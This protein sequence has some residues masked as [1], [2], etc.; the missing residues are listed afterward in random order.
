MPPLSPWEQA[1]ILARKQL[2]TNNAVDPRSNS[3][4][5]LLEG[6]EGSL[7]VRNY[8]DHA[9]RSYALTKW[10]AVNFDVLRKLTS[11]KEKIAHIVWIEYETNYHIPW[12]PL[13]DIAEVDNRINEII[14]EINDKLFANLDFS[15]SRILRHSAYNTFE[16]NYTPTER[17]NIE[18]LAQKLKKASKDAKATSLLEAMDFDQESD[19]QKIIKMEEVIMKL[20]KAWVSIDEETLTLL[21][22]LSEKLKPLKELDKAY[23]KLS[24]MQ[25]TVHTLGKSMA[26]S[27]ISE[28]KQKKL[29]AVLKEMWKSPQDYIVGDEDLVS[30]KNG[31]SDILHDKNRDSLHAAL[32]K[33]IVSKKEFQQWFLSYF[34]YAN[35]GTA[36]EELVTAK[37]K[38]FWH[39]VDRFEKGV[40]RWRWSARERVLDL[41]PHMV[42]W[43][44]GL[45]F[46]TDQNY[47]LANNYFTSFRSVFYADPEADRWT[48]DNMRAIVAAI[49]RR[50]VPA[51][52]GAQNL[53]SAWSK[54]LLR[55]S[56]G[57]FW[58]IY[59]DARDDAEI[60]ATIVMMQAQTSQELYYN[61][62]DKTTKPENFLQKVSKRIS[63]TEKWRQWVK[64]FVKPWLKW[65]LRIWENATRYAL[66]GVWSA[67]AWT[68]KMIAWTDKNAEG[69]ARGGLARMNRW[70]EKTF[71]WAK[72]PFYALWPAT[73]ALEKWFTLANQATLWLMVWWTRF[74]QNGI[75]ALKTGTHDEN[76]T[77]LVDG[78][79]KSLDAATSWVSKPISWI[80][81]KANEQS[82]K[83]EQKKF[84]AA[85]YEAAA[86]EDKLTHI[87]ETTDLANI[88][89][90][91]D[92]GPYLF[93]EDGR[94]APADIEEKTVESTPDKALAELNKTLDAQVKKILEGLAT[95]RS[96]MWEKVRT[97][98][99]L[100]DLQNTEAILWQQQ[101]LLDAQTHIRTLVSKM[102]TCVIATWVTFTP[103]SRAA[104]NALLVEIGA[105]QSLLSTDI[106]RK[107]S[108]M[109]IVD[110]R[111]NAADTSIGAQNWIIAAA[112]RVRANDPA[113]EAALNTAKNSKQKAEI[114]KRKIQS[115][116]Q[117]LTKTAAYL[118]FVRS[119]VDSIK[120][121]TDVIPIGLGW[122]VETNSKILIDLLKKLD[123]SLNP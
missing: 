76:V 60:F 123:L 66:T 65:L 49:I 9:L 22:S 67:T 81:Q 63:R 54:S 85:F 115:E 70:T 73:Y 57:R 21:D 118:M 62:K 116:L 77:H 114:E 3:I 34:A 68:T 30:L 10:I 19:P 41:H 108:R 100:N 79:G 23:K 12:Q 92:Y 46:G 32:D 58:S 29:F 72:L 42:A 51:V 107:N 1:R 52:A 99:A 26:N 82:T 40:D 90:L 89:N 36:K 97:I 106:I 56:G 17:Q 33:H 47:E 120:A 25:T 87:M 110:R 102:R 35:I 105:I 95:Q 39:K 43:I 111:I 94:I 2:D 31:L 101:A 38:A 45:D 15:E 44:H 7:E 27:M 86:T 11:I 50:R 98:S 8:I 6:W 109:S 18:K 59:H 16:P 37:Q 24:R 4:I 48:F 64:R 91:K 119:E 113:A 53:R 61:D 71:H 78:V 75:D 112:A 28:T 83:S 103:A 117:E 20:T 88:I 84:L 93:D 96:E 14:T 5:S 74:R 69:N 121:I 80:G 104:I 13:A 55:I 122:V